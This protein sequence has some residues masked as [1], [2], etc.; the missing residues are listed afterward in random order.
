MDNFSECI[1]QGQHNVYALDL[2]QCSVNIGNDY[3]WTWLVF[4]LVAV[5]LFFTLATGFV[6]VRLLARSIKEMLGS[7]SEGDD[8]HG[9]GITPFQAFATGL[10]SRVGT[11][12]IAGV[13]IA[14]SL[15][16]P[17]AVLW[18]WLTALLGMSSAFA[19]SS[20][21]QLFKIRDHGNNQ[22]RGGPAYYITRGMGQKWLGILF[23]L[24]LILCFGFVFNAIQANTIIES[25][26]SASGCAAGNA[27]CESAWHSYKHILGVGLVILTAPIIFGGIRRVSRIAEALVPLMA[28]AYLLM[29]LFVVVTNISEV[30]AMFS[31]IIDSAFNFQSAAGGFAGSAVAAAM[32]QGI[33]RG[34]FSNEAGM[35]SA[36]NAA[37]A[38]DV[39]HPVSQGMIQMLGVFVDTI[40]VCSCTA[41]VI[42]LSDV[43]NAANLTGSQLTQAALESQIGVFGQYFLAVVLF[44]FCYSSIIGNYAYAE[45][46][47]QFIKNDRLT[48][49]L[50]R[51]AVLAFVYFGS[52]VKV[53]LVWDMGDLSM[54]IMAFINLV[55]IMILSPLVFMLLRDYQRKL[56]MGKEPVFKLS[57]HPTLKRKIKSDVW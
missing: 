38:A 46:N 29:A 25:V 12:N 21:A 35:G 42:L 22:F 45:S 16:G 18:M 2:I 26:K 53:G 47:M 51:M 36:P 13:A 55:A 15:G 5:G 50:F 41:F 6:Q 49:A 23:A 34:L 7:R 40:I 52:V 39:K 19:E 28:S 14:I 3:V 57:E 33:K 37:A 9:H 4:I 24:S 48:L 56:R 44:M 27:D 17:G 32:Q 43:P 54:G 10:A 30:P 11:G 8:S 20:L 31:M 1:N